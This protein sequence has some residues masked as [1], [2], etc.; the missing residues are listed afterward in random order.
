MMLWLLRWVNHIYDEYNFGILQ[1]MNHDRLRNRV[2]L[3]YMKVQEMKKNAW[4]SAK[5]LCAI[6]HFIV[7]SHLVTKSWSQQMIESRQA[8]MKQLCDFVRGNLARHSD[9]TIH[10]RTVCNHFC[11]T[12][13]RF[14]WS[15]A[16]LWQRS[17]PPGRPPVLE[18]CQTRWS[19]MQRRRGRRANN[20]RLLQK[21]RAVKRDLP[22]WDVL[23]T[24]SLGRVAQHVE[25]Q[26]PDDLCFLNKTCLRRL[27]I[28]I[29]EW[30]CHSKNGKAQR[31]RML[32]MSQILTWW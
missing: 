18:L 12:F 4:I 3:H 16:W 14:G 20:I 7:I 25:S 2:V 26:G 21:N 10:E 17:H 30:D 29:P 24:C 28:V 11:C 6:S 8:M 9:C 22:E 1:M 27:G 5:P 19:S 31:P 23:T 13:P 32:C 15:Q